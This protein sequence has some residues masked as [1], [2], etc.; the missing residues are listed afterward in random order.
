M[1]SGII[2]PPI[3]GVMLYRPITLPGFSTGGLQV[4]RNKSM[5]KHRD[6][7]GTCIY[8]GCDVASEFHVV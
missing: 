8:N 7:A 5:S 4:L 1:E 2:G 6:G 3:M